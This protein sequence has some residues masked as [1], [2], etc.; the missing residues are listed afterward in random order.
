[1]FIPPS[2][3]QQNLE[4]TKEEPGQIR[5]KSSHLLIDQEVAADQWRYL[6]DSDTGKV[7]V[8]DRRDLD[9]VTLAGLFIRRNV[10]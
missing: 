8:T 3:L 10:G 5:L 1:M 6:V 9:N 7:I 4:P 2:R